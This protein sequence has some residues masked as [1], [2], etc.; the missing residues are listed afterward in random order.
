MV[1]YGTCALRYLLQRL[2]LSSACTRSGLSL[3]GNILALSPILFAFTTLLIVKLS[4]PMHVCVCG[5]SERA[6]NANK[7]EIRMEKSGVAKGGRDKNN[8][9]NG[10]HWIAKLAVNFSA[11][12]HTHMPYKRSQVQLLNYLSVHWNVS[13]GNASV[14]TAAFTHTHTLASY[15]T[16]S[17]HPI[18]CVY[19]VLLNLFIYFQFPTHH[20]E[21]KDWNV[22]Q[23]IS[24]NSILFR[25]TSKDIYAA[26]AHE[27]ASARRRFCTTAVIYFISRMKNIL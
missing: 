16:H 22:K 27:W 12:T 23:S 26:R 10:E 4:L 15:D 5:R 18:K 25:V 21:E 7:T 19:M 17:I 13:I 24:I 14:K 9:I 20:P 3:Y 11:H 8:Q 2:L 6:K 1:L